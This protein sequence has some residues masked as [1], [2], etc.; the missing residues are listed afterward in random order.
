[1]DPKAAI[2]FVNDTSNADSDRWDS[3]QGLGEWIQRGGFVP[4]DAGNLDP[5]DDPDD[6]LSSVYAA[7]VR[8]AIANADTSGLEFF[9]WGE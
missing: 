6:A 1:M 3:L 9:G 4:L 7:A 8:S 2:A 5:I